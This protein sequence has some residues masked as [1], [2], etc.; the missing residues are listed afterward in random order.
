MKYARQRW[1]G[2]AA[3]WLGGLVAPVFAEPIIFPEDAQVADDSEGT[4]SIGRERE[5]SISISDATGSVRTG[6]SASASL[7]AGPAQQAQYTPPPAPA[8]NPVTVPPVNRPTQP[9]FPQAANP[10]QDAGVGFAQTQ[11]DNEIL[12]RLHRTNMDQYGFNGGYTQI[13]PFMPLFSDGGNAVTFLNPRIGVSDYAMGIANVGVGHRR[14]NPGRNRV[15]GG[16]FWYDYDNGHATSFN[17]LG[18]S[19]EDIGQYYSLRGNL[20]F[21]V[22]KQ[23]A[24]AGFTDG[25]QT[26]TGN[27]ISVLRNYR[28][29]NAYQVYEGE[30]AVPMPVLGAYGFDMGVGMYFLNGQ[31]ARD[32]TG[33]S[34]RIQSQITENF[35]MNGLYTYD[36]VFNSNFSLNFEFT[37]PNSMPRRWFRRPSVKSYLTQSVQRRY[38]V[39]AGESRSTSSIL[40]KDT[41]G[42]V[43]TIA[44][45]DPDPNAARDLSK[46][47]G[48]IENPY[49]ST[50]EYGAGS[51][52][53]SQYQFIFV[54]R[55]S[56]A[57]E[58]A[59]LNTG[60]ELV[61]YDP[62]ADPSLGNPGP[63]VYGQKLI[64]DVDLP[65]AQLPSYDVV[66]SGVTTQF[67]LPSE[68]NGTTG[69]KPTLTNITGGATE[70][71][72]LSGD[73]HEVFGLTLDGNIPGPTDIS[74]IATSGTTDGFYIHGNTFQNVI[75]GINIT[76][77]TDPGNPDLD[78][79]EYGRIVDNIFTGTTG[80]SEQAIIVD[81]VNGDLALLVAD[82]T[83][84]NFNN[85]AT[86][87][88]IFV[89]ADG[90]NATVNG[91]APTGGP[92]LG[93]LR[94]EI[95]NSGSGIVML[96]DNG[97]TLNSDVSENTVTGST[98]AGGNGFSAVAQ[99]ASTVNLGNF[100]DN[101]F[102]GG[103][104]NGAHL[105]ATGGS[106]LTVQ[107]AL[108]NNAFNNNTLDG[109]NI[110]V[111][112]SDIAM[113]GIGDATP[114]NGNTFNGNG[115]DGLDIGVTNG[116][117]FTVVDPIINNQFNSNGDNGLVGVADG[118]GS[119]ITMI[120]GDPTT[121]STAGNQFNS[122]GSFA[123]PAPPTG[124]A[125]ISFAATTGA[126]LDTAILNN[127]IA[128]NRGN[129]IQYNYT[130]AATEDQIFIQG[131]TVLANGLN[132][133][134]INTDSTDIDQIF[135]NNNILSGSLNGDGFDF[136]ATNSTIGTGANDGLIITGNGIQNNNGNGVDVNLDASTMT[137][138]LIQ[139]NRGGTS[140]A[141]GT[142]GFTFN[143]LIWGTTM[144]NTSTAGLDI[145]HVILD[146]ALSGQVWRPDLTPFTSGQFLP[147]GGTDVTTG[148]VSVN[149]NNII[150]GT[151][152]LQGS[153]GQPLAGGG[154]IPGS[155]ILD[156]IFNSFNPGEQL[157]YNLA[158]SLPANGTIQN[159]TALA[160]STA[161]VILADGRSATG[162]LTAA[163]LT[164]N[165]ALGA[166]YNGISSNTLDGVRLNVN[167]G[168]TV[169]AIN[170]DD[171]NIEHNGQNGIELIANNSTLPS[172]VAPAII[173]NN[174][175]N[176]N[177]ANGVLLTAANGTEINVNSILNTITNNGANG[178]LSNVSDNSIVR[179]NVQ[180][181][182][183]LNNTQA[184]V[185][186]NLT[187]NGQY[188]M[189]MTGSRVEGNQQYGVF[190]NALDTSTYDVT[191]GSLNGAANL[192]T[193]N[194]DVGV[195]VFSDNSASGDLR[196][197]NSVVQNTVDSNAAGA[198]FNGE[199]ISAVLRGSSTID[200]IV[201]HN[202][203]LDNEGSG[204]RVTT[205]GNNAATFSS[206][207]SFLIGGPT[208]DLGNLIQN[209][210]VNGIEFVR[211]SNGQ[212][213]SVTPVT[214]Q[215]NTIQLN[216]L[217]GIYLSARNALQTDRYI[218]D[219]NDILKNSSN[220][221]HLDVQA[222]AGLTA[223]ITANLID[224]NTGNGILTTEIS[225]APADN[226]HV[227]GNWQRN[228]ITNNLLNGIQLSSV[229]NNLNIGSETD[230]TQLNLIANNHRDGIDITGATSVSIGHN[231]ITDNYLHGIDIGGVPNKN[232]RVV[233]NDIVNN[234]Y[235]P[236]ANGEL[237]DGI[238]FQN[239]WGDS[240]FSMTLTV[241]GNN[242]A[243]NA[244][245]GIDILNQ[246]RARSYITID[247]DTTGQG[248]VINAN[249]GEGIYV[250][251]T[252]SSTQ[253]QNG[254]AVYNGAAANKGLN[255][256]GD[257]IANAYMELTINNALVVGNGFNSNF[258]STGIVIRA[259]STGG[260]YGYTDNGGF[261][262]TA[263]G[264]II[265]ALTNNNLGGNFGDD[266]YIESF[267]STVAPIATAGTWNQTTF[268]VDAYEG[269]SLARLDLTYRN[270]TRESAS[271]TRT[272]AYFNNTEGVFK[273]RLNNIVAPNIPGPFGSAVRY[274][275]AQRLA[276][277]VYPDGTTLPPNSAVG[278]SFQF[279]GMGD[280]TFR[281]NLANSD[282]V[283]NLLN[284][285]F[286]I[287]NFPVGSPI[288]NPGQMN[289]V[290]YPG[291]GGL[292]AYGQTP[293]GW[294]TF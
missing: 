252:A 33:V 250:V 262:S 48:T 241:L 22:G 246:D 218:I 71:V 261:A 258:S 189:T 60:I 93:V 159:G 32:A 185:N 225:N 17:Q 277:R 153:N 62:F 61:N 257:L 276:D 205:T 72:T 86:S 37:M 122:N 4:V 179:L 255:S 125:G 183:V 222:D 176:A 207:D 285:G 87:G 149:G 112:N 83:I 175:I 131:N 111:D 69:D 40:G 259:G 224:G 150:A 247:S 43:I 245:R 154:V 229:T 134:T 44:Y 278:A 124:G 227:S 162:V 77:D 294:G 91:I 240:G 118:A 89:T 220:G 181:D 66:F 107:E 1:F 108:L 157:N 133:A 116:A 237:G 52:D 201:Q 167:N 271:V 288:Q 273:S 98:Q 80:S 65:T 231:M 137:N 81:H 88:G 24:L 94:N 155:T 186:A 129:G 151:N 47:R 53:Q 232:V 195:G 211:T 51:V 274:R 115:D 140:L 35:W 213:G 280:S 109:L 34:A 117:T 18:I 172:A 260:G 270:N 56:D 256:D 193:D 248:N 194:V 55:G 169:D 23:S 3:V 251:N 38:R 178:T 54:R 164:I 104:G 267:V 12:W 132:G 75:N 253:T 168:S 25:R 79:H 202:N 212:M 284:A 135:V 187:S 158:H 15:Y 42:N 130:N 226:R 272:G 7:S 279:A 263:R 163:G 26:F 64:G 29:E 282:S 102:T 97:G 82:N 28:F 174:S 217:N 110:T 184:G 45:I 233:T 58:A 235:G 243:F 39:A 19:L 203:I 99:N 67:H 119:K 16:S 20:Y 192:I 49:L 27:N 142:L 73:G 139:G 84:S 113:Q 242:I 219:N 188:E 291:L 214:I 78:F 145:A 287:D 216:D 101:T 244:G 8:P 21:P 2:A 286:A 11:P 223:D 173:T 9:V 197:Y 120:I 6:Q 13:A 57:D 30:F 105:G 239:N 146:S 165:Q 136:N 92:E 268:T 221:V 275:N 209:N 198:L 249:G 95:T 228:T 148:L 206:V 234:G 143:N 14:F 166:T 147:T 199:G 289:G 265:A 138:V 85:G 215:N 160:G 106:I 96:G 290:G 41:N 230:A 144:A 200:G 292:G 141:A 236:N 190:V 10:Y 128:S 208:E 156:L 74:G 63:A 152:P 204:I 266:I 5:A 238:E 127:S 123:P 70:V 121:G 191:V 31:T 182:Q 293:W 59:N 114:A 269:D 50:T 76:S 171:N 103:A 180:A 281:L 210:G 36:K 90:A 283:L 177:G 161:T 196:V 254:P 170:I 100:N 126:E 264:G 68:T 46:P